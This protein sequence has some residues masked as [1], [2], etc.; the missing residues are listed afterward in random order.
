M[1][2]WRNK[3]SVPRSKHIVSVVKTS[4][5]ML[6]REIIVFRRVRKNC[7][8]RLLASLC[9]SV[10]MEQ[11]GFH[12]TDSREIWY[13]FFENLSIKFIF[14]ENLTVLLATSHADRHM[15]IYSNIWLNYSQNEKCFTQKLY[16][17][18]KHTFC[19]QWLFFLKSCRLWDNV[20]KYG[21][22]GQAADDNMAHALCMLDA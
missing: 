21:R 6:Y 9:L 2:S 1:V 13:V 16:R 20:A 15:H 4:Q 19:V 3:Q 11:L 18:S 7:E 8:K 22:A 10:H 14:H 17:K 12:W 5:L